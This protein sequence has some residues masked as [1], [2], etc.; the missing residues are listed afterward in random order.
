VHSS[1]VLH[2]YWRSSS[3][4]RVRIALELKGV[5]YRNEAVNLL[6]GEQRSEAHRA[7]NPSGY[8]PALEVDG[9]FLVESVA[10]LE[11][12]EE[13][14]PNPPLLPRAALDRAHVRALVETINAGTQ[15]LQNL[16]VLGHFFGSDAEAKGAWAR[17]VIA[18][19]LSSFEELVARRR[20][21]TGDDAG[22]Y[23]AGASPT[24]ADALLVPQ[25]YNAR[26]FQVDLAPYPHVVA[27][28][29]ACAKLEAFARAHPDVQPD[30][31][32]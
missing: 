9:A 30:A 11:W 28:D 31:K 4:Y 26:R 1:L 13:A 27:V 23:S 6:A 16:W 5:R 19:G 32:P 29:A 21:A 17:Q 20:A 22:P 8:V 2:G 3:A 24:F 14:F 12:L 18:R 10:I 7:R 15:P 25:L